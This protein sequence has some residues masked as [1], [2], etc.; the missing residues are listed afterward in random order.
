M[1]ASV[2]LMSSRGRSGKLQSGSRWERG[3]Q[4]QGQPQ[5]QSYQQGSE[6]L[7][8]PGRAGAPAAAHARARIPSADEVAAER[9]RLEHQRRY[10]RTLRTTVYAL[11]VVAAA[12]VLVATQLLPVLQVSGTSMEPTLEDGDVVVLLNGSDY[13]TGDLVGFY[14]ENKL[15]LKRI[16]AGPGDWVDIDEDGNVYVNDV[17]L[18]EDYVT[19]KALGET[20]LE[21]PYQV[22]DG[23][24]FVLGDHR[25]TSIDSRS[26]QIG[27]VEADQIVGRV[28]LRVWPLG[29]LSLVG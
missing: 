1:S 16:I 3:A 11:I 12:A 4:R 26:S 28:I 20:D 9:D 2:S 5:P 7:A 13:E 19:D 22:P 25:S 17:L 10:R 23:R 14:Y 29:S 8:A 27:C 18:E 21:Y 24:Y 6:G 15:L